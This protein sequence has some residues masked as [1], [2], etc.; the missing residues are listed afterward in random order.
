ML[1]PT[2]ERIL[3]HLADMVE[4]TGHGQD[5]HRIVI[6]NP[7][8]GAG[9]ATAQVVKINAGDEPTGDVL[10]GAGC[11]KNVKLKLIAPQAPG[12]RQQV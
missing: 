11:L 2:V 6:K 4:Q 9:I 7:L 8:E 5:V 1:H 3:Q 10:L 12:Q